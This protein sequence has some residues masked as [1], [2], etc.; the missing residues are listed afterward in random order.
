[1]WKG[2]F[3]RVTLPLTETRHNLQPFLF[4]NFLLSTFRKQSYERDH[5]TNVLHTMRLHEHEPR[6]KT[7]RKKEQNVQKQ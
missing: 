6:D 4:S 1:M 3:V 5:G 2:S 7:K